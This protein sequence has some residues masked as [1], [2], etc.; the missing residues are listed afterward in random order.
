MTLIERSRS[1]M[2]ENLR[3]AFHKYQRIGLDPDASIISNDCLG[4]MISH[5]LGLK[6]MSP[7]INL[8]FETAEDYQIFSII[9]HHR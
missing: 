2:V 7:T 1:W 3:T 5:D 8:Y 9:L 4:G 6:F